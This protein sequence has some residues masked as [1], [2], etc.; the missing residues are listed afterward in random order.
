MAK[1]DIPRLLSPDALPLV[2]LLGSLRPLGFLRASPTRRSASTT[3][4]HVVAY[5][6]DGQGLLQLRPLQLPVQG[7]ALV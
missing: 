4:I 1:L 7:A 2:Q 3:H 6:G 5:L